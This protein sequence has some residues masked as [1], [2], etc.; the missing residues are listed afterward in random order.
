MR[1]SWRHDAASEWLSPPSNL[2]L[3]PD[4]VHVWRAA[5]DKSDAMQQA[6]EQ[7]LSPEERERAGRFYF[8]KDRGAFIVARGLLRRILSRYLG[9]EPGQLRFRCGSH[10]K[11]A[12]PRDLNSADL[13]FNLSHSHGV[14]LYAIARGRE[15]GVD[16]EQI[17]P[18]PV[19]E[20][21]AE[22]FFSAPEVA[23]LRALPPALQ[24]EGFFNCWTRK[25]AYIKARGEGLTVSLSQFQVSLAPGEPAAL[26]SVND[27]PAEASR[28][29]LQEL[30]PGPGYAAALA[31]EGAG[32][33]LCCWDWPPESE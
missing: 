13:R 23:A 7:T 6:L 33:R 22:R 24:P 27:D 16:L 12:L 2:T 19:H 17:R 18:E 20:P 5:L 8:E 10:G 30:A 26:V 32:W 29:A 14:A 11:P 15:V 4:E 9:I 31:V 25:E 28:W 3:R 21:I 1:K